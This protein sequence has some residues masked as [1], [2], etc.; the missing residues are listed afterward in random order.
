MPDV[1]PL[2]EIRRAAGRV[3]PFLAR[4]PLLPTDGGAWL[5]LEL[6]QPTGSFKVRGFFAAA[7]AL[8]E[9]RRRRGLMT[10]SAG[11]AALACAH[12]ARRLGVPCRVVMPDGA[13]A[14]KVEGV[15]RLGGTPLLVS[16]E[17]LLAWLAD[18]SWEGEPETFIHPF[19]DPAV[20]AGHG[21]IGLEIVEQLPEV[22]RVVVAV[23]GG[24]LIAGIGAALEQL[25]PSVEVV[26]VQSDG[27]PLWPR[28][29]AEGRPPA[30]TPSTIADG[31]TAPY[32][33]AMHGRLAAC[34]DRWVTV[35]EPRL[36]AAVG[37]LA[38]RSRVV[39]EGAGALP[40]AAL[41]QLPP[42]PVTVAVIS[43][44][45][46]DP[47]LLARLLAEAHRPHGRHPAS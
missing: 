43:G 45:N 32:D 21:G 12:V 11:N 37:E 2:E 9:E 16:R 17:E 39:A 25:R 46:I 30:L 3:E 20:Q 36:R 26:G 19:A 4:T 38:V 44:G 8:P 23:G 41:E 27:Y 34:V 28:T 1:I 33:A 18:R 29:F 6:L 40:A 42:G 14:P 35:P 22:E 7:L 10:V 47:G 13:P 5:K 24:G 15:R 31:T